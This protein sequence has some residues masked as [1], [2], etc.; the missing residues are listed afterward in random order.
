M[1][2]IAAILSVPPKGFPLTQVMTT[3]T[4]QYGDTSSVVTTWR[5]EEFTRSDVRAEELV[6]PE[7]FAATTMLAAVQAQQ[8]ER[9]RS[10]AAAKP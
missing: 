3:R 8:L 5:L 7:G 2:R 10:P 1:A 6:I 9:E 4:I